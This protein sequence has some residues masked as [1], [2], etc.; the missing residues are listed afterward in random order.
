MNDI[1][2][3]F[4]CA[5]WLATRER[6]FHLFFS[7]IADLISCLRARYVSSFFNFSLALVPCSINRPF[8]QGLTDRATRLILM[9]AIAE[10][11]AASDRFNVSKRDVQAALSLPKLQLPHAGSVEYKSSLGQDDQL[12]VCRR[13]QS[14]S[15]VV[16]RFLYSEVFTA[17]Q[18][19][20]GE[21]IFRLRKNPEMPQSVRLLDIALTHQVPLDSRHL[22]RESARHLPLLLFSVFALQSHHRDLTLLR[23][24]IGRAPLS[25]SNSEC[26]GTPKLSITYKQ[27][28]FADAS[29]RAI[30]ISVRYKPL[31]FSYSPDAC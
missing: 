15:I 27:S 6:L 5:R 12:S 25:G 13:V 17:K 3:R 19:V 26:F 30:I 21:L 2:L 10:V 8:G 22:Q 9:T 7:T 18:V 14:S 11:T 29:P 4:I 23:M 16:P 20:Y 28:H 31:P 24:M 1:Y